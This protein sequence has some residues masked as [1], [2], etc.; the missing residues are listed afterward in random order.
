[1]LINRFAHNLKY[2]RKKYDYTQQQIA[3]L[4]NISRSVVAKWENGHVLPDLNNTL[5]LSQLF[6]ITLDEFVGKTN[7]TQ[8]LLSDYQAHYSSEP[9]AEQIDFDEESFNYLIDF[10][11]KHPS[12]KQQLS[13]YMALSIKQQKSAEKIF[14]SVL[15][16][17]RKQ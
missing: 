3:D 8:N 10:I 4:L 15:E 9:F 11:I 5:K 6:Q 17:M 13:T 7:V 1:M 16:E 14:A 2:Y 12:L